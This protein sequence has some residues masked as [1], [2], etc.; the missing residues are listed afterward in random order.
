[1]PTA[2]AQTS[3]PG[4]EIADI[5]DPSTEGSDWLGWTTKPGASI[6]FTNPTELELRCTLIA[7]PPEYVK[8]MFTP[9]AQEGI[10]YNLASE[11][12]SQA[13]ANLQRVS[14]KQP[15]DFFTI[16]TKNYIAPGESIEFKPVWPLTPGWGVFTKCKPEYASLPA[17]YRPF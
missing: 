13:W 12:Y 16:D 9:W 3:D 5:S 17:G 14:S 1:M 7:G 8:P 4:W 15:S 6:T 10:S 11:Q 2:T